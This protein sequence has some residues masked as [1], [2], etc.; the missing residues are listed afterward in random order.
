[1]KEPS[2]TSKQRR[3]GAMKNI[4]TTK[5]AM[6]ESNAGGIGGFCLCC[7]CNQ[8][9]EHL[10]RRNHFETGWSV[11]AMLYCYATHAFY[12]PVVSCCA[13]ICTQR[14]VVFLR[15]VLDV[16]IP[17]IVTSRRLKGLAESLSLGIGY[18]PIQQ[19]SV[20]TV[21]QVRHFAY[22]F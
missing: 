5:G 13:S 7:G 18:Q 6:R 3:E 11:L 10:Y 22:V 4:G 14:S 2:R 9:I 12:C 19:A 1:M 17:R 8:T 20:L 15:F 16:R 21:N